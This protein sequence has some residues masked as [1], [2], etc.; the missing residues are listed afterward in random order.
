MQA[1]GTDASGSLQAV[2]PDGSSEPEATTVAREIQHLVHSLPHATTDGSQ[3]PQIKDSRL[4][5]LLSNV[6]FM[7]GSSL[8]RK[9]SVWAILENLHCTSP[10]PNPNPARSSTTSSPTYVGSETHLLKGDEP[11]TTSSSNPNQLSDDSLPSVA[12]SDTS[13]IM[14][15]SPLIPTQSD[16]VELAELVPYDA[17]SGEVEERDIAG[18]SGDDTVRKGSAQEVVVERSSWTLKWPF[19]M[20]YRQNQTQQGISQIL[21]PSPASG[22]PQQQSAELIA[23]SQAGANNVD[24]NP[25]T[26]QR[27]RTVKPQRCA[28]AWVPSPSK[29]SVQAFWWGYRL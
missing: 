6:S 3:R 26:T 10:N 17:D 18:N 25:Q 23:S 28:R 29:I 19:S 20:W 24:T 5:A 9:P 21:L 22:G 11:T 8:K 15:Y 14:V 12:F 7:N 13:S 27:T 16:L 2:L 1:F 4:I